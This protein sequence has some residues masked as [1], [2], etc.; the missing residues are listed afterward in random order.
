[1]AVIREPTKFKDVLGRWKTR[2]IFYELNGFDID[3]ALFT[4]ECEDREVK[5]KYLPSLRRLFLESNDITGYQ[6]ANEHLGGWTHWKALRKNCLKLLIP[7]WE[8]ELEIKLRS[9]GVRSAI[10]SALNGGFQAAKYLTEAQ[11]KPNTGGRKS[12]ADIDREERIMEKVSREHAD[13]IA[14]MNAL[15]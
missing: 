4:T 11:W 14:R 10:S 3:E 1:M 13:D 9:L 2:R 5:G 6:V 8:E 12:K 7:D 15:Q